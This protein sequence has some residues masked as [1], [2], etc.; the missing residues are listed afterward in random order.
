[1]TLQA[2]PVTKPPAPYMRWLL[3]HWIAVTAADTQ[4]TKVYWQSMSA[5][6]P[7]TEPPARK[8]PISMRSALG[9]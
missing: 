7:V 6:A 8:M 9:M 2:I 5:A 1:M 3:G 4:Q